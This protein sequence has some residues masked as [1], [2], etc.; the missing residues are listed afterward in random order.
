[1]RYRQVVR[2]KTESE[3]GKVKNSIVKAT[4]EGVDPEPR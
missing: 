2:G 3:K 1:M 4:Q